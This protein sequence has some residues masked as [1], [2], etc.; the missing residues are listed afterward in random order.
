VNGQRLAT[1]TA[2]QPITT[3]AI[4]PP[5]LIQRKNTLDF[6]WQSVDWMEIFQSPIFKLKHPSRLI[7]LD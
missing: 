5:I 4:N 7:S 6:P 1:N 3:R 2:A